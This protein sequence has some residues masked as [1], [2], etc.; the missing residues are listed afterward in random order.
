MLGWGQRDKE[1]TAIGVWSS[2]GHAENSSASVLQVW[3][4]FILECQPIDTLTSTASGS[5]ITT[6][7]QSINGT[8]FNQLS[9]TNLEQWNQE[10][11][12][13]ILYCHSSLVSRVR[14]NFGTSLAPRSSRVPLR[15]FP[16]FEEFK[17]ALELKDSDKP[18]FQLNT[19][20]SPIFG[21]LSSDFL[22]FNFVTTFFWHN[23]QSVKIPFYQLFNNIFLLLYP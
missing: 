11:F 18:C 21:H 14:Q 10:W 19:W 23:A 6:F 17:W 12:Y 5:W 4:N 2:I 8:I 7:R 20:W 9:W 13:G 16:D 22:C 3:I 15:T 1:L